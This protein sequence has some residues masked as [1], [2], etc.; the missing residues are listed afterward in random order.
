MPNP[1]H[2]GTQVESTQSWEWGPFKE[3]HHY[4][5]TLSDWTPSSIGVRIKIVEVGR[6][7][8]PDS[9][10]VSLLDEKGLGTELRAADD[11]RETTQP[12]R[13]GMTVTVAEQ[14]GEFAT[15]IGP[16]A[17]FVD[18]RMIPVQGYDCPDL[19]F[20]WKFQ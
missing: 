10:H 17:S 13:A 8:R 18:V 6:C 11:L 16:A 2:P 3:N 19:T 7:A 1:A 5:V 20:R 4:E 15:T 9:Y 12:G 14:S